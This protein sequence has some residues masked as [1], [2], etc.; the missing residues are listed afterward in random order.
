MNGIEEVKQVYRSA[1]NSTTLHGPTHFN[2]VIDEINQ[3]CEAAELSQYH[4][5]Y[6]ILLILTDGIIMD[7]DKTI[8]EI[9][10]G[11]D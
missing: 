1:I 9:V 11:S 3:R 2:E 5:E 7:M 4:Q 6:N 8:D 10:R